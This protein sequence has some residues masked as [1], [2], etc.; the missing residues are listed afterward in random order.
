[1]QADAPAKVPSA[2]G[3]MPGVGDEPSAEGSAFGAS[4]PGLPPPGDNGLP[5]G[6]MQPWLQRPL[7]S[8]RRAVCLLLPLA[9]P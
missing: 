4:W 2:E 7:S 8:S 9:C 5:A 6:E 3:P 1:M